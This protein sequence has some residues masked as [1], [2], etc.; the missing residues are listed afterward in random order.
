MGIYNLYSQLGLKI[1]ENSRGQ[2]LIRIRNRKQ[3][4]ET[5]I[6]FFSYN[7][8]I[9]LNVFGSLVENLVGCD[10]NG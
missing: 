2:G 4:E 6:K 5:G 7:M 9:D 8:T 3:F 1:F 10:L